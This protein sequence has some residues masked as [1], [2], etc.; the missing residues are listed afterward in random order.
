MIDASSPRRKYK[1]PNTTPSHV[2]GITSPPSRNR[3]VLWNNDPAN[4]AR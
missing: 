1:R 4:G 2:C 3:G